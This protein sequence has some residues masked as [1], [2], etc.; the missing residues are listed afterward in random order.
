MN[1][2][3]PG[4]DNSSEE[5]SIES[6][7]IKKS[8]G[9][10]YLAM[11][12]VIAAF[13]LGFWNMDTKFDALNSRIDSLCEKFDALNS[14]IDSLYEKFAQLQ[15]QGAKDKELLLEKLTQLQL[16]NAK[17]KELLND[18]LE[19]YFEISNSKI[20]G[21]IEEVGNLKEDF[22]VLS[23]KVENL[24]VKVNCIFTESLLFQ[25]EDLQS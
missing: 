3:V 1:P 4:S 2:V 22:I 15:N 24:E 10:N 9:H 14:R 6:K 13:L 17:D 23:N 25:C 18:K 19:N 5:N 12:I 21:V 7:W 11:I 16:Q 20:E 8:I